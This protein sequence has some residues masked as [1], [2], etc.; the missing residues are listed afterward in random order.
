[1][2]EDKPIP[3]IVVKTTNNYKIDLS[4]QTDAS[5][6]VLFIR[7]VAVVVKVKHRLTL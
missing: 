6:V 1:M 2:D 3:E 4:P 7:H 5:V